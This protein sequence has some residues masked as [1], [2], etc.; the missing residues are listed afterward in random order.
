LYVAGKRSCHSF[1]LVGLGPPSRSIVA[2]RRC[3][4]E[5]VSPTQGDPQVIKLVTGMTCDEADGATEAVAGMRLSYYCPNKAWLV[6]APQRSTPTPL[7]Y[8]PGSAKVSHI[9]T[10]G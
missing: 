7:S 2:G 5:H 3:W 8:A 9:A 1:G 6:G 10:A 4:S